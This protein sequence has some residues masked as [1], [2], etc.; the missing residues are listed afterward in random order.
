MHEELSLA[1]NM[2]GW[3]TIGDAFQA[4]HG[5]MEGLDQQAKIKQT[6]K[7]NF[8]LMIAR[9]ALVQHFK[10][11]M[12]DLLF[13]AIYAEAPTGRIVAKYLSPPSTM[14]AADSAGLTSNNEMQIFESPIHGNGQIDLKKFATFIAKQCKVQ[15]ALQAG[16]HVFPR[17]FPIQH[18]ANSVRDMWDDDAP[19]VLGRLKQKYLVD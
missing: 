5:S 12:N 19:L 6:L 9:R 10:V 7:C 4:F 14:A 11:W 1:Y 2:E 15:T 8:F 18:F 3:K 16:P 17:R 13:L